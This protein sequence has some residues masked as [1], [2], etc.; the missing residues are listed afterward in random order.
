MQLLNDN[1][2]NQCQLM[3]YNL[4]IA[5][6]AGQTGHHDIL[7]SQNYKTI[8]CA[9]AVNPSVSTTSRYQ[10]LWVCDLGY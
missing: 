4:N 3:K 10:G 9:F 2:I 1:G 8:G 5:Y 7:V 6:A